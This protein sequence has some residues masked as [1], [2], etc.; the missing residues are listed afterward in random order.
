MYTHFRGDETELPEV[1]ADDEHIGTMTNRWKDAFESADG[2]FGL[3]YWE[4]EGEMWTP[5]QDGYEL[6]IVILDGEAN[7]SSNDTDYQLKAGDVFVQDCPIPAK[8]W[9]SPGVRA[10]YIRRRRQPTSSATKRET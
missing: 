10:V 2:S 1:P 6:A 7:L 8:T 5:A 4:F 9:K 3:G